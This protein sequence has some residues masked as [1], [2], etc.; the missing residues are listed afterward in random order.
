MKLLLAFLTVCLG[1]LV[2]G[3]GLSA[4]S[5]D[6]LL[7]LAERAWLAAHPRIVLGAAEDWAATAIKD[8]RGGLS[9]A[10]VEHLDL[11]NQKLGTDIRIEVGP[12]HEMV[13]K[14]EAGE[15]DGLTLTA[16]LEERKKHFL[17]TNAFHKSPEFIYLRTDDLQ[18]KGAPIDLDGL[19]GKRV[20]Y[21]KGSLRTSRALAMHP[22]ITPVPQRATRGLSKASCAAISTR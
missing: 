5:K 11:M 15:I 16:P 2:A 18:K 3:A 4:V 21:L 19:H 9:G 17:F 8:A 14:A 22:E 13:R 6:D 12:W 1:S 10:V 7:T 20:G